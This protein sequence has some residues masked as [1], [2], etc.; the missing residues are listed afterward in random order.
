MP[1]LIYPVLPQE[2]TIEIGLIHSGKTQ[3]RPA[4]ALAHKRNVS[5][6]VGA[7]ELKLTEFHG[8]MARTMVPTYLP[9]LPPAMPAYKGG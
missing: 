2:Q 7:L 3:R 1:I 6:D 8:P 4:T 9:Y 5:K